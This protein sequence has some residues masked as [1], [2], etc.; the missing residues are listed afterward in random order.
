MHCFSNITSDRSVCPW[1]SLIWILHYN[2]DF[3]LWVWTLY[4]QNDSTTLQAGNSRLTETSYT[5]V[6]GRAGN[7]SE[8][9]ST[10]NDHAWIMDQ[11]SVLL[12][13]RPRTWFQRKKHHNWKWIPHHILFCGH[14]STKCTLWLVLGM[15]MGPQLQQSCLS[16]ICMEHLG[17]GM[18]YPEKGVSS[19]R[20]P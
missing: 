2:D 10:L 5:E 11:W 20:E 8:R 19:V 9:S 13:E 7:G 17:D 18:K 12:S 15:K 6:K 14:F 1:E 3:I 16:L 4:Q